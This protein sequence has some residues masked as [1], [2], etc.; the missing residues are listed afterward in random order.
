MTKSL[1]RV[2]APEVR[3][4]AVAPAWS[5]RIRSRTWTDFNA[6]TRRRLAERI[7]SA[8]TSRPRS[9]PAP[10]NSAFRPE[11]PWWSTWSLAL[12]GTRCVRLATRYHHLC[13]YRQSDDLR[14]KR[15]ICPSPAC[16]SPTHASAPPTRAQPLSTSMCAIRKPAAL[17]V[18]GLLQRVVGRIRLHSPELILNITT[19]GDASCPRLMS[20]NRGRGTTLMRQRTGG[21]HRSTCGQTSARWT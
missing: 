21:A 4:L 18:A 1:A 19:A 12:E 17:D 10:H 2:L 14:N 7:A 6:K 3:V 16:K 11:R 15:L 20:R 5:T 8:T 13:N 9:S